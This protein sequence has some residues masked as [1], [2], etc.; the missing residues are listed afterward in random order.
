[1]SGFRVGEVDVID[2]VWV[3]PKRIFADFSRGA[4]TSASKE[5]ANHLAAQLNSGSTRPSTPSF[6]P[7][8]TP[9]P[10]GRQPGARDDTLE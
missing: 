9:G 1:M 10:T 3:L 4:L 5:D 2:F 6:E 8:T 7:R